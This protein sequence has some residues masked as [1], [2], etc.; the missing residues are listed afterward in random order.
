MNIAG[1]NALDVTVIG[2]INSPTTRPPRTIGTF[3]ED[4]VLLGFIVP[5]D[6]IRADEVRNHDV[7]DVRNQNFLGSNDVFDFSRQKYF[8]GTKGIRNNQIL[9]AEW[10]GNSGT[11][12][13]V[14]GSLSGF[15][16]VDGGEDTNDMYAFASDGV[17]PIS[18]EGIANI[19]RFNLLLVGW[20]LPVLDGTAPRALDDQ[21]RHCG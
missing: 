14:K 12:V 7:I 4:E 21:F 3:L 13:R 20:P 17:T 6:G 5:A 11:S 1:R 15:D 19:A 9:Q 18:I 16:N 10:I 2:D 8:Y